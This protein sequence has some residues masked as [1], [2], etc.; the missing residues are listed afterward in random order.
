MPILIKYLEL[1]IVTRSYPKF[2]I[3]SL[4]FLTTFLSRG[5]NHICHWREKDSQ[6]L[7]DRQ[8]TCHFQY[9]AILSNT[10]K[11]SLGYFERCL[12]TPLNWLWFQT[13]SPVSYSAS[14]LPLPT[15]SWA[16]HWIPYSSLYLPL[17]HSN[18]TGV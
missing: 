17:T 14:L 5:S 12:T 9:N 6:T 18:Y 8:S 7:E 2:I 10:P 16:L 4:C 3:S 15:K 11:H 1:N 13:P